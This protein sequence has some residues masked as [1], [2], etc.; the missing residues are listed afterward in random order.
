M[1]IALVARSSNPL[2]QHPDPGSAAEASRV[3]SLAHALA[4]LGHRVTVYARRDSDGLPDSAI[5]APGVT[6]EHVTAGPAAPVDPD[7]LVAYLPDFG[8]SLAQ[9]WRRNAPDMVHAYF[10]TMGLAALTGA[11][12]LDVPVTQTFGSLGAAQHRHGLADRAP[13]PRSR[14]ETCIARSSDMVLASSA[15]E[16]ADLARLGVPRGKVRVVPCGVDSGLF[17]PEGPAAERG[18]RPRL[19]AAEPLTAPDGPGLAVRALAEIPDAELVIT[20]GPGPADPAQNQ[21][22]RHLMRLA[23]SLQVADRLVFTGPVAPGDLPALLRSADLLVSA[24]AY[25]PVGM[26][27]LQAMACGTPVVAFAAGAP[28]DAVVDL[29][30]GVLLP[31]GRR[32]AQVALRIRQLLA[33]SMR[34]EAYG[35]AA[36]DRARSRYAW[37]RVARE[38][39]AAYTAGARH[40]MRVTG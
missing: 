11:R 13:E 12:G 18:G 34:L 3:T 37:E 7:D 35:I 39:L 5:L 36:A 24:A 26:I 33:N 31:P 29:T 25:E 32:P 9:H 4:A 23:K 20:G 38:T 22:R 28:R 19:L 30:T 14:L 8:A 21:G 6:V 27:A 16:L 1:R 17:S 40:E 2:A 10:W 15:E